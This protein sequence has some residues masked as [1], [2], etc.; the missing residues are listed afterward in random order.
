MASL[1]QLQRLQARRAAPGLVDK[2]SHSLTGLS[3]T[4]H[5]TT[6]ARR[7]YARLTRARPGTPKPTT[8]ASTTNDVEFN[9]RNA[10]KRVGAAMPNIKLPGNFALAKPPTIENY[11][12]NMVIFLDKSGKVSMIPHDD[13]VTGQTR[14]EHDAAPSTEESGS[15]HQRGSKEMEYGRK[16]IGQVEI[17]IPVQDAIRA[18]LDGMFMAVAWIAHVPYPD[19]LW[20][21]TRCG[22]N[23]HR[24]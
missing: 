19:F 21:L 2:L 15:A 24:A 9:A 20:V 1:G 13:R 16:R 22:P 3:L 17:P 11:D 10:I 14:E 8:A 5:G 7:G 6:P 23:F 18:V 4:P 12:P